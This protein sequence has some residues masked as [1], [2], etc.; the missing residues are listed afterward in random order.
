MTIHSATCDATQ[1]VDF[2]G[3]TEWLMSQSWGHAP[4]THA[5][6]WMLKE[7]FKTTPVSEILGLPLPRHGDARVTHSQP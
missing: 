2:L 3:I 6:L 5:E 1:V 7:S 4:S